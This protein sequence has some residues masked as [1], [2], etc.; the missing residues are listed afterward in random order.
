MFG[1]PLFEEIGNRGGDPSAVQDA[2][3]DAIEAQLGPDMPLR[4]L[5]VE[6]RWN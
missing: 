1:N 2:I 4:A 3:A 5:V 6:A